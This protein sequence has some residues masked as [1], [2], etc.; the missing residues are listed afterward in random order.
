MDPAQ[1]QEPLLLLLNP[2]TSLVP[3]H[4]SPCG[5]VPPD[6]SVQATES[7]PGVPWSSWNSAPRVKWGLFKDCLSIL[8]YPDF[9]K[10]LASCKSLWEHGKYFKQEKEFTVPKAEGSIWAPEQIVNFHSELNRG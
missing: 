10:L 3:T 8:G 7:S 1:P 5:V 2:V 6:A 9:N 4:G